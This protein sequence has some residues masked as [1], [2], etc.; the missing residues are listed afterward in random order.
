MV[1]LNFVGH[2]GFIREE[3]V[4]LRHHEQDPMITI[5]FWCLGRVFYQSRCRCGAQQERPTSQTESIRWRVDHR[6]INHH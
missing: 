3:A 2:P 6:C 4:E 5:T 1:A